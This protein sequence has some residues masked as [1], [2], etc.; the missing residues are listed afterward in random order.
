LTTV[1]DALTI[2]LTMNNTKRV[3]CTCD[4]GST[5]DQRKRGPAFAWARLNPNEGIE[6]I[7]ASA[8]ID[9][10]VRRLALDI[11]EGYS[12]ALGFEAPLFIPVPNDSHELSKGREG[13]RDRAWAS[14]IGG[15]VSAL[16]IHQSA[17]ILK[18]LY[19]K[20]Q[21]SLSPR[22]E[23]TLDSRRWPPHSNQPIL[24]CWE[25]FVSKEAHSSNHRKDA[26]TALHFFFKHEEHL[27]KEN[28]ITAENPISLIGAAAL[29]SG[30]TGDLEYLHKMTLV[31]KP[32][33]SFEGKLNDI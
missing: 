14:P 20:L 25:A 30:W 22:C 3:I 33:S 1:I 13:D 5:L 29:W 24:F 23:F 31:L 6:S 10:L 12:V 8:C 32:S 11:I 26:A 15:Y 17:W 2:K 27:E 7:Q 4:V 16:G 28:A 18:R 21:E 19:E 9:K